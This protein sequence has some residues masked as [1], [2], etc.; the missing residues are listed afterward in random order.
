MGTKSSEGLEARTSEAARLLQERG[1]LLTPEEL[2]GAY[3]VVFPPVVTS[4]W[5]DDLN[6]GKNM[7]EEAVREEL[8]QDMVELFNHLAS[9]YHFYSVGLRDHAKDPKAYAHLW[10]TAWR[11]NLMGLPTLA[12]LAVLMH[13]LPE[14]KSRGLGE[15]QDLLNRIGSDKGFKWMGQ[16]LEEIIKVITD[17]PSVIIDHVGYCS[18]RNGTKGCYTLLQSLEGAVNQSKEASMMKLHGSEKAK[19]EYAYQAVISALKNLS[20]TAT[21]A[22]KRII[23]PQLV[24]VPHPPTNKQGM[25]PDYIKNELKAAVNV[26]YVDALFKSAKDMLKRE[27]PNE[28]YWIPVA[29]MTLSHIDRVRTMKTSAE[30]EKASREAANF[31]QRMDNF[32]KFLEQSEIVNNPLYFLNAALKTELLRELK[33]QTDFLRHRPDSAFRKMTES[34]VGRYN[35]VNRLYGAS[36]IKV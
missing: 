7:P 11:A 15:A 3:L 8:G 1:R 26:A 6:A 35:A 20:R 10:N 22:S 4:K 2:K 16:R 18:K 17:Y 28:D 25:P 24:D 34:L 30:V 33:G 31:L 32:M 23:P 36:V 19:A 29:A 27:V 13:E 14:T 5:D 9:K 21:D 12:K